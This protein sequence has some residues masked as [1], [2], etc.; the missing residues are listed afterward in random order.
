[1]ASWAP[2]PR[3]TEWHISAEQC[4]ANVSEVADLYALGQLTP[5]QA[6]EFEDHYLVCPSC[7]QAAQ[8]AQEFVI[9]FRLVSGPSQAD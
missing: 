6:R 4:P 3:S 7:A 8:L 1:M 5:A 2:I 9:A